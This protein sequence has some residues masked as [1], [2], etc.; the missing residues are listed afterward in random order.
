[1]SPE[2]SDQIIRM[3][4]VEEMHVFSRRLKFSSDGAVATSSVVVAARNGGFSPVFTLAAF[5]VR[6]QTLVVDIT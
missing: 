2:M 1:V 4:F 3:R 6:R 5:C